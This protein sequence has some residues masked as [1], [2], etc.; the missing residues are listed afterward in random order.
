MQGRQNGVT[1]FLK[2]FTEPL[3][4]P[5]RKIQEKIVPGLPIDF[6]PVLA[7]LILSILSN[8]VATLLR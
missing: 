6:S 7:L 1:Q 4:A 8:V 3:L 5:G 2:V